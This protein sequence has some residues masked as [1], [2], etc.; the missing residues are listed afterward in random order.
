MAQA[1]KSAHAI[2][3]NALAD[4]AV[5]LLS[6]YIRLDTTNPPG[7]ERVACDWLAAI[8]DREGIEYEQY[9]PAPGRTSLVATL[10]GD[11]PGGSA[12]VLLHHSDTVPAEQAYWT[13]GPHAG[14]VRDG[15]VWGRGALDMKGMGVL[16]LLVLLLHR[17]RGLPLRRPLRLIAVADEES[18]GEQG[19]E[20]LNR[21]HP[22]TLDCAFVINEGG[23]GSTEIFGVERPVF[24]IGVAEKGPL[25]VRLSASGPAGH[26]SVPLREAA[27]LDRLVRALA[28]VLDWAQPVEITPPVAAYFEGLHAASLLPGAPD[29]TLLAALGAQHPRVASLLANTIS[30]TGVHGGIK[31]NVIPGEASATVDARL[32]P[33]GDPGVFLERLRAVIA[34]DEIRTEIVLTSSTETSSTDTELYRAIETAVRAEVPDAVVVPSVSTGSTD[35]RVFRRRGI[36]AYGFVPVLLGPD[37]AGRTHGHDERISIANLRLGLSLLFRTVRLVCG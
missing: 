31:H 19:I 29:E 21:A 24:Q 23:T 7:N 14:A 16:E 22:E 18:G 30:L 3:W 17:R 8:L 32:L 6:Q 15:Y 2:D 13:A 36:L 26:G 11:G 25:W 5:E 34:D 4:E 12:L 27:A 9:E 20:F 35:S 10:P 28:R 37:E 1:S 33:G